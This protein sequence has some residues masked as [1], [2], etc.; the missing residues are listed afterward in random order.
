M[1]APHCWADLQSQFEIGTA[2]WVQVLVAG[3]ATCLLAAG[4]DGPHEW[5]PDTEFGVCF[6][7][8]VP[9]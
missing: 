4:H 8:E 9:A 5:T 6:T 2:E 7:A 1:I 3:N